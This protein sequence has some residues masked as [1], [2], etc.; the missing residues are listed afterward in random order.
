MI[1]HGNWCLYGFWLS[2][3]R[4]VM[5]LWQ[6][7]PTCLVQ[8]PACWHLCLN[9]NSELHL[10]PW[11]CRR[12]RQCFSSY[13]EMY[14]SQSQ[15]NCIISTKIMTVS[16]EIYWN[17]FGCHQLQKKRE[18]PGKCCN[19]GYEQRGSVSQQPFV[20]SWYE[21]TSGSFPGQFETLMCDSPVLQGTRSTT[22]GQI[23]STVNL[24]N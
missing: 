16:E 11:L 3:L 2:L 12:K 21:C 5:E 17:G 22:T 18:K 14:S 6:M 1:V 4:K 8:P 10:S 9:S 7:T 13:F 19:H 20:I 24:N 23:Q 15:G